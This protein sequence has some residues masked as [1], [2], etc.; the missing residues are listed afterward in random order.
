MN[1]EELVTYLPP[2][3]CWG[4]KVDSDFMKI[5]KSIL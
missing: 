3:S 4:E 5:L 1:L 2:V